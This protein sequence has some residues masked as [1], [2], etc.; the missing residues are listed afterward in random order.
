[1]LAKTILV[2]DGAGFI[3][4]CFVRKSIENG[5]VHVVNVDALTYAGSLQYIPPVDNDHHIFVHDDIRNP[6]EI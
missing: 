2:T 3:G 5:N 1:M 6:T 4:G